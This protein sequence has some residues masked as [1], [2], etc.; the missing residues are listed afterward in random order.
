LP[1]HSGFIALKKHKKPCKWRLFQ[2]R[3]LKTFIF[4]VGWN[5]YSTMLFHAS[6]CN[7]ARN[8]GFT[9][10]SGIQ[11]AT[12]WPM[13]AFDKGNNPVVEMPRS[14]SFAQT[15]S[16]FDAFLYAPVEEDNNGGF[17]SVLSALAR[18][19]LDPWTEAGILSRMAPENAIQ[20]LA[21]LISTL[22]GTTLADVNSRTIAARL[23]ALLPNAAS[24]N[25]I[26]RETAPHAPV[27]LILTPL[28]LILITAVLLA[29][30]F[31]RQDI[32]ASRQASPHISPA[33]HSGN[34]VPTIPPTRPAE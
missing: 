28:Y 8:T 31:A 29:F 16:Q 7:R 15:R 26:P 17:L 14:V 2:S 33:S 9:E 3:Y 32:E 1:I 12:L 25:L 5:H 10:A 20:R 30:A 27:P 24:F 19:D 18:S 23:I 6:A 21:F 13:G 22:P 11:S 34:A 4:A